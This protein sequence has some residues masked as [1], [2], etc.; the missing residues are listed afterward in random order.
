MMFDAVVGL[1]IGILTL[2]PVVVG[3]FG[4]GYIIGEW[5]GAKSIEEAWDRELADWS[6][7]YER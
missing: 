1:I 4:L 3:A 2:M 5:R 6:N 7:R